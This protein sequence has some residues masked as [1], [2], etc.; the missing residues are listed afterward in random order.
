MSNNPSDADDSDLV[1]VGV[2]YVISGHNA[3]LNFNYN[4]GDANIS[5]YPGADIK[6]FSFGAQLQF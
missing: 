1:E 4:T 6:S 3:R 5:G 2:N